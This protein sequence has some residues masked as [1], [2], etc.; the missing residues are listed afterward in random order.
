MAEA[1]LQAESVATTA[2]IDPALLQTAATMMGLAPSHPDV[3]ARVAG[4]E[5]ERRAMLYAARAVRAA[6]DALGALDLIEASGM[7]DRY[8]PNEHFSRAQFEAAERLLRST[9]R[10]LRGAVGGC[11]QPEYDDFI[12]MISAHGFDVYDD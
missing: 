10:T 11:E 7:M 6:M 4:E 1:T 2:G 8:I 9:R 5:H 12:D 3:A